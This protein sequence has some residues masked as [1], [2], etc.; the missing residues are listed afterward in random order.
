[1]SKPVV[2]C[3]VHS[4]SVRTE[5]VKAIPV[6]LSRWRQN[7]AAIA[8]IFDADQAVVAFRCAAPAGLRGSSESDWEWLQR[9][10]TAV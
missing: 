9:R 7:D 4:V 1:M 10:V 2:V 3:G 5:T 6:R 8:H